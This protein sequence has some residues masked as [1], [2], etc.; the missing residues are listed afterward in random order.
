VW[1]A[2]P[3]Q[4]SGDR[5]SWGAFQERNSLAQQKFESTDV[6][7]FDAAAATGPRKKMDPKCSKDGL[8]WCNPPGNGDILEFVNT[9]LVHYLSGIE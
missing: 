8:H 5:H 6:L 2:L 7:Y 1:N 9:A 3:P 4:T